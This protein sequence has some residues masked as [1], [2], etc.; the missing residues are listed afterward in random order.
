MARCSLAVE[1]A[2]VSVTLD[3]GTTY[4]SADLSSAL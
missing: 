3:N 2:I 4:S 1:Q